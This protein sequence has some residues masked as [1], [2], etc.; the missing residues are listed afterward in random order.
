MNKLDARK[1]LVE[2]ISQRSEELRLNNLVLDLTVSDPS[3][4]AISSYANHVR[5]VLFLK[6]IR[7]SERGMSRSLSIDMNVACKLATLLQIYSL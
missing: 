3:S 6:L 2:S 7:F 5:T 4:K 1:P